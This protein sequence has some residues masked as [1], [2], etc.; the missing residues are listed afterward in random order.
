MYGTHPSWT[1]GISEIKTKRRRCFHGSNPPLM[2]PVLRGALAG[3]KVPRPGCGRSPKST[4]LAGTVCWNITIL[5]SII[6]EFIG[7]Q[8][9][10][11]ETKVF[12]N[13]YVD[14]LQSNGKWII[15]PLVNC[16]I[17]MENQYLFHEKT[18]DFYG[19]FQ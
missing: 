10:W 4:K 14:F 3:R 8:G 17:P 7:F 5:I 15:Y 11:Q 12:T 19:H 18:Q 1:T 13:R 16:C 9:N 6:Y 2:L